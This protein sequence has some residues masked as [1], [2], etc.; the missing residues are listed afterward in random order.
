MDGASDESRDPAGHLRCE[1]C[2]YDLHGN[3]SGQGPE[4]GAAGPGAWRMPPEWRIL[5]ASLAIPLGMLV[6]WV[7]WSVLMALIQQ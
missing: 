7:A 3:K 2:G 5:V 6:V 4:C 1:A